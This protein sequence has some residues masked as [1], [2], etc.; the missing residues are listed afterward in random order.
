MNN[1]LLV[2]L[3]HKHHF[4]ITNHNSMTEEKSQLYKR[5]WFISTSVEKV[6]EKI[7]YS[8]L[9]GMSHCFAEINNNGVT[10]DETIMKRITE[11]ST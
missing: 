11:L 2:G 9:E 10:Y 8:E 4:V 5:L 3:K 6:P 7:S 1:Q